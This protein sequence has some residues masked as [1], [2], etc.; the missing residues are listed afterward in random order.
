MFSISG[1]VAMLTG[2]STRLSEDRLILIGDPPE[3]GFPKEKLKESARYAVRTYPDLEHLS[4]QEARVYYLPPASK[5]CKDT[6][7]S[8]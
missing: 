7:H 8:S 5:Y 1:E 3:R 6:I 2:F 4:M